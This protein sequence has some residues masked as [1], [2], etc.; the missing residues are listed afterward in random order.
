MSHPG[1]TNF[2]NGPVSSQDETP[3]FDILHQVAVNIHAYK[4]LIETAIPYTRG[5]HTLEDVC[6]AILAGKLKL[7]TALGA[8]IV[9]EFVQYPRKLFLHYFLIAGN[10]NEIIAMQPKIIEFAHKNKCDAISGLGRPGWEKITKR[11]GWQTHDRYCSL[12]L[13][14]DEAQNEQRLEI[15][16]DSQSTSRV[17]GDD[18]KE[19]CFS[20]EC[21]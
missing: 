5:T 16:R 10:M 21:G 4:E 17:Y 19:F 6:L 14:R 3:V 20:G 12:D 1:I 8:C 9:S 11:L 13:K 7:W 2:T 15:D 18:Q